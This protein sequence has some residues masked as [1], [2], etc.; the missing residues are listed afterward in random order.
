M[1]FY[2]L[3][4]KVLSKLWQTIKNTTDDVIA[5]LCTSI[6]ALCSFKN[7]IS[8]SAICDLLNIKMSTI[9]FQVK[10][11]IFKRFRV[12]GFVSL[13]RSAELLRKFMMKVGLIEGE[14]LDVEV[15][16]EEADELGENVVSIKLGETR[17]I[18]NPHNEHYLIEAVGENQT[19]TLCYLEVYNHSNPKRRKS[20]KKLKK[21]VWFGLTSSEYYPMKGPPL[22]DIT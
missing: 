20:S 14:K 18:F 4:H 13:V 1:S 5:G 6:T 8:V 9:Q 16:R 12:P 3:S 2:F 11:R 7:V 21:D 10:N 17:R 19:I 22:V 15:I